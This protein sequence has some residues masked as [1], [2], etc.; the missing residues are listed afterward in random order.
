MRY[1]PNHV[2]HLYLPVGVD[3][4]SRFQCLFDID[5]FQSLLRFVCTPLQVGLYGFQVADCN[6]PFMRNVSSLTDFDNALS[7]YVNGTY[8]KSKY[9]S[10][11]LTERKPTDSRSPFSRYVNY[12]GCQ[13]A[14][15]TDTDDY[16]ARYTT[17]TICNGLVQSSKDDC[18]LSDDQSRPLCADTCVRFT[19]FISAE[20]PI[21]NWT[22]KHNRH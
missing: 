21:N 15:L 1:G 3:T 14:N 9:V 5:Q 18:N 20:P 10:S 13:G 12:L 4:L 11:R 16:Y 17:S 19:L 6:S 2:R 7:N 22:N 8:T